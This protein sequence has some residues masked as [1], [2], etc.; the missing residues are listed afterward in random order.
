V[1]AYVDGVFNHRKNGATG[2]IDTNVPVTI[3]DTFNCDQ[4]RVTCDYFSG[5]IDYVRISRG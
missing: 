4:V 5:V 2:T 3:G 1:T